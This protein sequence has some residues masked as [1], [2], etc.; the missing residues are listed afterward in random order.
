MPQPGAGS[1]G[2]PW[3]LELP[4]AAAP[5][6]VEVPPRALLLPPLPLIP[7]LAF[8]V[9][10]VA[11]D[12][13]LFLDEP[14]LVVPPLLEAPVLEAR[15]VP[16]TESPPVL[17]ELAWVDEVPPLVDVELSGVVVVGVVVVVP[18][19]PTDEGVCSVEL[20]PIELAKAIR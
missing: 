15:V 19:P 5:A 18:P 3:L 12:V 13:A 8:T 16:V 11:F 20:Q 2:D 6:L 4:P 10:P 7:L 17:L 1:A 9:P 14:T